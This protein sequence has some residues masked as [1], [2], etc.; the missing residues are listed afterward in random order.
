MV[1][2][3]SF[4]FCLKMPLNVNGKATMWHTPCYYT[5]C[6]DNGWIPLWSSNPFLRSSLQTNM[7]SQSLFV[8]SWWQILTEEKSSVVQFFDFLMASG[9]GGF[10]LKILLIKIPLVP[11][12][13]MFIITKS[14]I[15]GFLLLKKAFRIKRTSS[16]D[17]W[18][19]K[20]NWQ[21]LWNFWQNHHQ[22]RIDFL[23]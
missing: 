3:L 5:I 11:I 17:F 7:N 18:K 4:L 21:L 19:N 1:K 13:K 9:I 12:L 10:F 8:C 6:E 20:K 14:Y 23:I 15:P 16:C 2:Y 22:F